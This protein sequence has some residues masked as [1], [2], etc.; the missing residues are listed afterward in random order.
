[1]RHE[2]KIQCEL[3][4]ATNLLFLITYADNE[5]TV[6]KLLDALKKIKNF[7]KPTDANLKNFPVYKSEDTVSA[8][9]SP[10]EIFFSETESV[11][12]E[13][14]VN[15]ICAEEITFYPPGIPILN[16]GEIITAE[17]LNYIREM[18]NFGGRIIGATDTELN[19]IKIICR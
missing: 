10:R 19:T 3:S 1:M 4:D 12:F 13:K 15:K 6:S 2:L 11:A 9:I 14:S 16:R 8:K 7:K 17:V 18:K 5:E